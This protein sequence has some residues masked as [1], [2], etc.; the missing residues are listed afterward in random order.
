[1]GNQF[2]LTAVDVAT[3]F[4]VGFLL[5]INKRL[6]KARQQFAVGLQIVIAALYEVV[7]TCDR[8]AA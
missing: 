4:P 3:Q 7:Q 1:M 2:V 5:A 8:S 6:P